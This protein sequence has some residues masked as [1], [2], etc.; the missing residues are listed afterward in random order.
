MRR[1]A[2]EAEK[3]PLGVLPLLRGRRKPSRSY[4]QVNA[5]YGSA[6]NQNED[7]GRVK[8]EVKA[9]EGVSGPDQQLCCPPK[10]ILFKPREHEL[11]GVKTVSKLRQLA[12][13]TTHP[14][15]FVGRGAGW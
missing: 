6:K 13:S 10:V 3:P 9:F 5:S 11:P 1:S 15:A 14:G 7:T 2:T 12:R 4:L 8:I